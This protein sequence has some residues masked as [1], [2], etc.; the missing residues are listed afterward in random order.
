MEPGWFSRGGALFCFF[1]LFFGSFFSFFFGTFF[2][3]FCGL[4]RKADKGALLSAAG[5]GGRWAAAVRGP[6]LAVTAP[7]QR[8]GSSSSCSSN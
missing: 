7:A 4:R 1:F 2:F 8:L 5:L 3:L 6:M